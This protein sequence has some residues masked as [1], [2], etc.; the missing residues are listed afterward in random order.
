MC[1][2]FG[3][4]ITDFAQLTSVAGYRFYNTS[5]YNFPRLCSDTGALTVNMQLY[6]DGWSP[7]ICALL[8]AFRFGETLERV[9]EGNLLVLLVRQLAGLDLHPRCVSSQDVSNLFEELLRQCFTSASYPGEYFSPPEVAQLMAQIVME[10]DT[11]LPPS[12]QVL[13]VYDPCCGTGR[14][15]FAFREYVQERYPERQV[16]LYGQE[17]NPQSLALCKADLYMSDSPDDA[18]R[19]VQG[20]TLA[21]DYYADETFHYLCANVPYGKSWAVDQAKVI[22]EARL[23]G[24]GRFYAGVPKVSDGQMLFLQHLIAHMKPVEEGGSRVAMVTNGSP[25]FNGDAGSG[26]SEIRRWIIE[27][28]LLEA[29]IALP[30]S[31]FYNTGI[32]SYI[33][34]LTNCKS[35]RRRDKIQFIDARDMWVPMRRNLGEKRRELSDEHS[36]QIVSLY[37][38]FEENDCSKIFASTTFGYRR[39]VVECPLRC[40]YQVTPERIAAICERPNIQALIEG[41]IRRQKWDDF[42]PQAVLRA[43]LDSLPDQLYRKREIFARDLAFVAQATGFSLSPRLRDALLSA[44]AERDEEAEICY[45][46][47]G[48]PEPDPDLR[49][50]ERV[51]LSESVWSFFDREVKPFVPDAWV[52]TQV[53]DHKDHEIG[54]VGYEINVTK[55]F[56]RYQQPRSLEEIIAEIKVLEAEGAK[57][58]HNLLTGLT[59]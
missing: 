43:F 37:R 12:S 59:S 45:D 29:I 4:G 53:R 26:E 38:S 52:S 6:L 34:L 18:E 54:Q 8:S 23:G 32:A 33:W 14:L 2:A 17:L 36:S 49:D 51:P 48:N 1:T 13:M 41:S 57:L 30:E 46:R 39:I 21:H 44:F 16:A 42:S 31:I 40:S 19:M 11:K 7:N 22:A 28:D 10:K 9:S 55:L 27:Q 56:Y 24:S 50:T 15:L 20:S 3:R 35:E 5:P 58:L 47:K 25:L